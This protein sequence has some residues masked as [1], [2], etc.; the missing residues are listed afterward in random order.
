MFG[1]NKKETITGLLGKD[2]VKRRYE[3]FA[4]RYLEKCEGFIISY[5]IDGNVYVLG[6]QNDDDAHALGVLDMA[7][8]IVLKGGLP[9]D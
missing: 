6:T 9:H 5:I 3:I 8:N 4:E 2:D 7:H 1:L